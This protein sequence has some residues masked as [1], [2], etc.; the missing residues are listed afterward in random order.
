MKGLV[1]R[2]G[3]MLHHFPIAP[4]WWGKA[5][6]LKTLV[7]RDLATKHKGS[8]L[9]NLWP[10][11]NQLSLLL[12]FTFV[13]SVIL[14]VKPGVRGLPDN[15]VTF[16]VWLYA[17]LLPWTTFTSGFTQATSSVLR[18]ANLVK[19]VVFPLALLPL[20]PVFSTFVESSLGLVILIGFTV[21]LTQTIHSTVLL[22]P[23]IWLPQLLFTAGL[24]YLLAGL[25]VFLRDI[26]QGLG[27]LTR[28]W[29]Y[30]T[31][32]IYPVSILP[33]PLRAWVFRLNPL[34]TITTLY[35][36]LVILG[37]VEHWQE[38]G[39]T[40]VISMVIF[41]LGL[42]CYQKLRPAFADVL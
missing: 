18:Q 21:I 3:N 34:A 25:T 41:F 9:G 6:L 15:N 13:F 26:P 12:I 22:L 10:L 4:H 2:G 35:R 36:E 31:P 17:G 14:K 42:K 19:K 39:I 16:G 24:G 23:L 8:V 29:M 37:K 27:L 11:I 30:L 33:E 38:W 28:L 1:D 5:D 20:V 40:T 32:I 7:Q